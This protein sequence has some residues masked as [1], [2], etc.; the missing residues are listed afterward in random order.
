M[1]DVSKLSLTFM[2]SEIA[3]PVLGSLYGRIVG[4]A[5]G[6]VIGVQNRIR[7]RMRLKAFGAAAASTGAVGLFHIAG[8]TPEAPDLASALGGVDP[9]Q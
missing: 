2:T 9:E 1:F 5:I 8:V 4:D 3:W 7:T 6:V